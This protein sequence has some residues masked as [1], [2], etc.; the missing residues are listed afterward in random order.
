MLSK[1][2]QY[3]IKHSTTTATVLQSPSWDVEVLKMVHSK[4]LP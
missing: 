1:E 3:N 4:A 2:K